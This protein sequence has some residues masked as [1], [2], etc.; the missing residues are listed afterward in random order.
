[1]RAEYFQSYPKMMEALLV[2]DGN[3]ATASFDAILPLAA[4]G[5]DAMSFA[6]LAKR[7]G[8]VLARSPASKREDLRGAIIGIPDL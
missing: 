7:P 4:E 5:R 8:I 3:I 1:M 6:C 2:G